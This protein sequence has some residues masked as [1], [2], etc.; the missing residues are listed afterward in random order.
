MRSDASSVSG[1]QQQSGENRTQLK[2][3]SA[4]AI[5]AHVHT[6]DLCTLRARFSSIAS[7][8]TAARAEIE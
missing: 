8:G 1:E 6:P 3:A 7:S 5:M 4:A 2:T